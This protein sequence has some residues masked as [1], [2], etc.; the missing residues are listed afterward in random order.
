MPMHGHS[1]VDVHAPNLRYERRCQAPFRGP[2]RLHEL[3]RPLTRT[4]AEEAHIL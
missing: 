4:L 3:L 1:S 2:N